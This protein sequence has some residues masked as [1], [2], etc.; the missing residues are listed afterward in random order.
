[1]MFISS[2]NVTT[3][4]RLEGP[5]KA[6]A[7]LRLH[8]IGTSSHV[9]DFQVERTLALMGALGHHEEL[10]LHLRVSR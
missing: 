6:T 8:S 4:V 7:V 5:V 3:H 10:K 9:W 1:M 2:G